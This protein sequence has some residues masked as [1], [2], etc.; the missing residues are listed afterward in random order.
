MDGLGK[1]GGR[2]MEQRGSNSDRG[3]EKGT[4]EMKGQGTEREMEG[5]WNEEG[6]HGRTEGERG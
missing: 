3:G 1:D 4:E 2:Q 6:G 5:R